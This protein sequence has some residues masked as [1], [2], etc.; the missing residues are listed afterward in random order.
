MYEFTIDSR[1]VL[2]AIL[3]GLPGN[4]VA[5]SPYWLAK[6]FRDREV[7]AGSETKWRLH[8]LHI[9]VNAVILFRERPR[10]ARLTA[11]SAGTERFF[12]LATQIRI[13]CEARPRH[14]CRSRSGGI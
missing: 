10:V 8:A 14:R 4:H 9:A 6:F 1:R 13:M 11:N 7:L 2:V 5:R 12:V 3:T